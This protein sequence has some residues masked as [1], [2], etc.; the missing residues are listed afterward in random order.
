MSVRPPETVVELL[1]EMVRHETVNTITSGNPL[2]EAKLTAWLEAVAQAWG[3]HTRRMPVPGR[4]DNLLVMPE[5]IPGADGLVFMSHIDTVTLKGMTIDPLGAT[6][7]DGKMWGR[8]TCDTKC[9]GAA[10][11]WALKRF[12]SQNN[13]RQNVALVFS[14]DEEYGML[15]VRQFIK[16]GW[17]SLGFKARGVIDG[18]PTLLSPIVAHN[19]IGRWKIIARG[20]ATHSSRPQLGRSAITDMFK[21]IQRFESVYIPNLT[22]SHPLTGKAQASINIIQGGVQANTIPAYCEIWMDRRIAPGEDMKDIIPAVERELDVLRKQDPTLQLEVET[23]FLC[24]PLHPDVS[25]KILP[26]VQSA[27]Q[28]VGLPTDPKGAPFGTE[29]GDLSEAGIPCIV[30]GPGDVTKAHT[31]DEWFEMS[32]FEPG[33]E[34]YF[35]MMVGD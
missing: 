23:L 8:G 19:G 25:T 2:A 17:N 29:G 30:I 26:E 16:D 10:M 32:Q 11:F 3:F 1:Q 6:I 20:K 28:R 21:V 33:V 24:P 15:G 9:T 18:E 27:L 34:M 7:K 14:L 4:G 35:Q 13:R 31:D 5:L 12:A 22:R